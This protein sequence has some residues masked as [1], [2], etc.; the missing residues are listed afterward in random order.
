[1]EFRGYRAAEAAAI[2]ASHDD[3]SNTYYVNWLEDNYYCIDI[4]P[5]HDGQPG[6][7][8]GHLTYPAHH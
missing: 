5:E 7:V 1:M 2:K 3:P 6:Y 8:K 4:E